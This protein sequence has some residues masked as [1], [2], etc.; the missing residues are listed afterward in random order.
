MKTSAPNAP[1]DPVSVKLFYLLAAAAIIQ[2]GGGLVL[3]LLVAPASLFVSRS[4]NETFAWIVAALAGLA[5]VALGL[6]LIPLSI[7]SA[8]AFRR[9]KSWRRLAGIAT[10]ALAVFAFPCGTIPGVVLFRRI[11]SRDARK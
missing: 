6:I 9:E 10:A 7:L 5:Q 8:L 4:E 3:G 1:K 2:I 11:L